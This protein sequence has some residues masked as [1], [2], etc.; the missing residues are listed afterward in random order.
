MTDYRVAS[1]DET[2]A[3]VRGGE[4]VHSTTYSL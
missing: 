1:R 2:L 3:D 4:P